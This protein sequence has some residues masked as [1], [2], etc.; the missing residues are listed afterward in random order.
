MSPEPSAEPRQSAAAPVLR[1]SVV[2]GDNIQITTARDV[3]IVPRPLRRPSA[4]RLLAAGILVVL[5]AIAVSA[6]PTLTDAAQDLSGTPVLDGTATTRINVGDSLAL[7]GELTADEQSILL[8]EP[9]DDE[10]ARLMSRHRAARLNSMD[11]VLVL[12]GRRNAPIRIIDVRPRVLRSGPPPAGTCLTVPAQGDAGEFEV[13]ADLDEQRPSGG[14]SRFLPKSID[15]AFGERATISFTS[16]ARHRW[17]EWDIEVVYTQKAG[18][19]VRSMFFR[20]PDGEPFRLSGPAEKYAT[21][22]NDP[23]YLGVGYRITARN[24]KCFEPPP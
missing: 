11:V 24:K 22:W 6:W 3:T 15:L 21:V 17:H 13:K 12:E 14:G 2:G 7:P 1:D 5:G 16:R 10:F 18:D 8:R 19:G 20:A 4:P 9:S 23:S